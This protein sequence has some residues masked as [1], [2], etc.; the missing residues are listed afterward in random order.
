MTEFLNLLLP[1]WWGPVSLITDIFISIIFLFFIVFLAIFLWKTIPRGRLF[2]GKAG[3]L[4]EEF[5]PPVQPH[6]KQQLLKKFEGDTAL[7]EAW[8]EFEYSLITRQRSENEE[9]VYKTD[10]ASLFFSEHRLL[11]QHL[12][13]RFWNSVPALLVGVGILGTF[14]GLVWG[15]IP[16]SGVDFDQTDKIKEAIQELLSGISTAFVSSV[17]GML[18]SLLFTWLEKRGIGKVSRAIAKLQ[19][20]LDR[21]FTLTTQEEIAFRQEDELAQQTQALKSFSTDLADEI[22]SAMAAGRREILEGLDKTP[23]AFSIAMAEKLAPALATLNTAKGEI[24][25]ELS[26]APEALSNAMAEKL[27]PDLNVLNTALTD[28][29]SSLA[30][31]HGQSTQG[32]Q[33][34]LQELRNVPE[35]MNVLNTALTDLHNTLAEWHG[36][37]TQG[38][39]EILQELR[40]VPEV[41]NV[42]NTA[43]ADLHNSL[44]EWHGQSTQGRQEILQELRNVPEVIGNTIAEKLAPSFNNL[45]TVVEELRRQKEESSTEAIEKLVEQFQTS[46]SGSAMAQME[47]LAETVGKASESL[48]TLPEQLTRVMEGVQEQ[49]QQTRNLLSQTSQEQA[50][51][52]KGM[53]DDMLKAFQNAVATQQGR[54]TET[55]E[56][57]ND[58]M[59]QIAADIRNLLE[60][61]ANRAD[62]QLSQ[63]I[64]EMEQTSAQSIQTLQTAITELQGAITSVAAKTGTET[65]EMV[66][67]L[68]GLLEATAT[69]TDEQLA[70]QTTEMEKASAQSIQTLQATVSE[71]QE[72]ITSVAAKTSEESAAMIELLR[73]SLESAATRT[74]E[75]LAQRTAEVEQASAQSI[76]ALQTA[77]TEL[78]RSISLTASQTS[79]ES[80]AMA[81]RMR[82]LVEQ[83]ADRLDKVFQ[84]GEQ[85]VST[86]LRQQG[87]QIQAVNAQIANSQETLEKGREMLAAMGTS[88][89]SVR[90]LLETINGLS[91]RLMTGAA[92]L[93]S[94]GKN[95]TQASEAFNEEN[96][97]Y[98]SANR[99]TIAELQRVLGQSRQLLNDSVQRFKTIDDGLK[100]I[101]AEIEKGLTTYSTTANESINTYLREFSRQLSSAAKALAG[102]V[103]AL[104]E[105]VDELTDTAERLTRWQGG[106]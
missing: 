99:E 101:F 105:V 88:L 7:E 104:N 69:R 97:K 11:E 35:V 55:T 19:R 39:Q 77:I 43:L 18:T 76:Q 1:W 90:Q 33:E 23:E 13:L 87:A 17:W 65:V 82:K 63:R 8:N 50:G 56:S 93:E 66:N 102:S 98:L 48:I 60:S 54:L 14:V 4:D 40:N 25:Q 27:A 92:Q 9:I 32:R 68:R 24:V 89:T 22:K 53:M 81:N 84:T 91:A 96:E 57:V 103:Q 30:E 44:A 29:H 83:S 20:A 64:A 67:R 58:E 6:I 51:Q 71:L 16:F 26:N 41:M 85:S 75:Q 70:Q 31:W 72:A 94:A 62:E 49:V 10:E 59:K 38:R 42:L 47:A 100:S 3:E 21:L 79:A 34:I 45:N 73:E 12:N 28:L 15:L 78:Q 5:R 36:Q 2:E 80:E 46:L 95:L 61:A 37:S 52:M 86:L 74:D 106:R